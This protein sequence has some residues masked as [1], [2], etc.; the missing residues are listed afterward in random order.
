MALQQLFQWIE[1]RYG[2]VPL[3]P[4]ATILTRDHRIENDD[5]ERLMMHDITALHVRDFYPKEIARQIGS[6]LAKNVNVENWK[7]STNRGLESSDVATLGAYQPYNVAVA[8][9]RIDNYFANVRYEMESRRRIEDEFG[10]ERQ[11]PQLWPLDLLRL[12]LDEAWVSGAGLARDPSN[13]QR[14]FGGGLP[15]IMQGPTRWKL[16]YVHVDEMLP[17]NKK[18]GLFSAN[19][20][21]QLPDSATKTT[22]KSS[23]VE[24]EQEILQIWPTAIYSRWD[25]YRNALL[26]SGLS[27]QDAESQARLRKE[28]GPP[29]VVR[30]K[31]GDLVLLCVQ[32]PHAAV[33]F[34]HGTRVSLQCFIQHS[35]LDKRL[36]IDS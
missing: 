30:A 17:L 22:D 5:L 21:L 11:K 14:F 23:V 13:K 35:G 19:I 12:T 28:L 15:R 7:I 25:W 32:R 26:L 33:G 36:L 4:T 10:N 31:P 1:N 18:E 9:G 20:Y 8:N 3:D 24:E 29:Q 6:T 27:M 2:G 34:R 16:G